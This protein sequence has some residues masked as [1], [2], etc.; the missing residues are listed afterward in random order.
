MNLRLIDISP[1][2]ISA[3]L[4]FFLVI[5]I[6][7][8]RR[9][10]GS[11]ALMALILAAS[12]W[13]TGY[14]FE[15][16]APD[17]NSKVLWAKLEYLGIVVI[18]IAWFAFVAQYLGSPGWMSRFLRFRVLLGILPIITLFL[19]WTNEAHGLIWKQ[20][21]LQPVGPLVILEVDHGPWFW[22][23]MVFSYCLLLI[24]SAELAMSLVS[25]VCLTRWQVIL[26]LIA[27]LLPWIGN[28]L[29][30]TGMKPVRGLDWTPFSFIISGLLFTISLIR[31]QLV[32]IS[33]I[34]QKTVFAGIADCL[35]VLDLDDC[36]VDLNPVAH[37]MIGNP[38]EEPFGKPLAQVLPALSN[39]V[40]QVGYDK[41]VQSEYSQ[42]EGADQ[43]YYDLRVSP[44]TGLDAVPVG[45]LI[46]LR[47]ITQY[48]QNQ[49][50]L[51]RA[52]DQLEETVSERTEALRQV[53][54]RLHQ[55]LAQRTMAEKRFADVIELAPDAMLLVDQEGTII[56]INQ[57]SERL[58]GYSREELLGK[59]IIESLVPKR[60]RDR[61]RSYFMQFIANPMESQ[62]SFGLDLIAQRQDGSEFPIEIDL[63]CLD[64]P[65]GF[66]VVFN[67][68]DISERKQAE[69]ALRESEQTY[70]VLFEN[71]GDAIFLL[72]LKGD[73]QQVNQKAANLLGYNQEELKALTIL[74]IVVPE[75]HSDVKQKMDQLL[76][77]ELLLPYLRHYR[78]RT[79]EVFPTENNMVLVRDADGK[80]KFFQNIVRD[81]TEHIK[82]EQAQNLL[83]EEIKQSNEQ[84]RDLALRLQEAQEFERKQI[85]AELHDRVGQNLTGLNLNLQ[86][87]QNQLNPKLKAEVR[88][89]LKDSLK[90][91]EETTH[92]VRD[93][94][95]DLN[96]PVLDEYGL[97]AA[98]Q[99]YCGDFSH[100][101]GIATQ[102]MGENLEP[103]LPPSVEKILFRLVQES[104]NNVAKHAQATRVVIRVESSEGVDSLIVEDNGLGFDPGEIN[105]PAS[106]PHWGLLSM[107]QRATSIGAQL[108]ID[109]APGR[110]TRVCV[111]FRRRQDD[112]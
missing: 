80:P 8:N 46:A 4:G 31:F 103:R 69:L 61:Q 24:A 13:S 110:G 90:M 112:N 14:A 108:A 15:I 48:K 44:L 10:P 6:A 42:G 36:I 63:S 5:F 107:Q 56:L 35:L 77:V 111:K 16:L 82:A 83:L 72:S 74:D 98:I 76:K 34:A 19:A 23:F 38:T 17:L 57:K 51:E 33:P 53:I 92:Q 55:E 65:D 49:A 39:R 89:R 104:L 47:Q 75:E 7:R 101:T 99:W 70:R 96:P 94:M 85:A 81:M 43:Q 58:F 84:M 21:Q 11:R 22:V 40:K 79:G 100:H 29:Y 86:I 50:E 9:A 1:L 93:V 26:A 88:S 25:F 68:H 28:I 91:V 12:L 73:I 78:K 3:L 87:L 27:I 32:N 59:N 66:W 52:R 45:R 71:A 18:P 60:H 67:I 62:T 2:L 102:V 64:I 30:I 54:E 37:K 109:S 95:A 105:G 97:T 41:E 106:P 20:V